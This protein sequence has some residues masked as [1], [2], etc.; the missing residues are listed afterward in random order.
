MT[1][2]PSDSVSRW[3]ADWKAGNAEAAALLWQWYGP[4]LQELARRRLGHF[5]G[6]IADE[7][8]IA[9]CVFHSF[10]QGARDGTFTQLD[11]HRD[12]RQVFQKLIR[13]RII[14]HLRYSSRGKRNL[15]RVVERQ[16]ADTE[17]LHDQRPRPLDNF[18]DLGSNHEDTVDWLDELEHLLKRL[19][20]QKIKQVKRDHLRQVALLKVSGFTIKQIAAATNYTPRSI[21][22]HLDLIRLVW[23]SL[24]DADHDSKR[25]PR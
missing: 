14:D 13:E 16:P 25:D 18:V 3:L 23:R 8:D 19:D 9:V 7:E 2:R 20:E 5:A 12:A 22:R 11:S 21:E 6:G 1:N 24:L 15:N 10:L 4:E 17:F